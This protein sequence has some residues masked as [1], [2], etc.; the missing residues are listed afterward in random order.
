MDDNTYSSRK[1]IL[2]TGVILAA[3]PLLVLHYISPEVYL[4]LTGS[5]LGLYFTG[6]VAESFLKRGV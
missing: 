1:F 6:N 2:A 5:T 4:T 3:I